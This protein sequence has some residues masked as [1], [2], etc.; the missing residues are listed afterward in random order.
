MIQLKKNILSSNTILDDLLM[1]PR[2]I[3]T[4]LVRIILYD[5]TVIR[6]SNDTNVYLFITKNKTIH[7]ASEH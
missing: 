6:H 4:Y 7:Y 3:F 2:I 5:S 1:I